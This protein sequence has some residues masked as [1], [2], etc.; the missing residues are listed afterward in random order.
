VSSTARGATS[1]ERRYDPATISVI[2]PTHGRPEALAETLAALLALDY[3]P[4][5]YELVV[6]ADGSD[7]STAAVVQAA[8]RSGPRVGYVEQPSSGVARARN[9]GAEVAQGELL[10]FLD[11]DLLVSPDHLAR[12]VEAQD[13]FGDVLANG[14]WEFSPA[15]RSDLEAT[16]FG[17]FRIDVEQWVK[18]GLPTEPIS[19]RYL[20]PVGVT[21]CNL[22]V[23]AETFAW[24]GGFDETFP[25]A[26][27]EDQDL[28]LRAAASGKAFVY[29]TEIRLL[30]N[31]RRLTL[32]EFGERQRRGAITHVHL[33]SRHPE[34]RRASEM[35]RENGPIQ[36]GDPVPRMA[37]KLAKR[38]LATRPGLAATGGLARVLELLAPNSRALWRTYWAIMGVYIFSGIREGLRATATT[39]PPLSTPDPIAR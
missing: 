11:D 1:A 33:A 6:V 25:Y 9:H 35:L 17:R 28:S 2:I 12:H 32:P 15:V 37:K 20:R 30:H 29:D 36:R 26:G 8:Q 18:E 22:G 13:R 39:G 23:R 14:H 27:C 4:D 10:V 24:L 16:P 31:D 5:R 3:P 34:V 7:P 19:E 21:A 38:A